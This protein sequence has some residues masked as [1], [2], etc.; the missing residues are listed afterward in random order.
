MGRVVSE[1]NGEASVEGDRTIRP[2]T[3]SV[4]LALE[5]AYQGDSATMPRVY[6]SGASGSRALRV[7]QGWLPCLHR[8]GQGRLTPDPCTPSLRLDPGEPVPRELAVALGVERPSQVWLYLSA[9][10][11]GLLLAGLAQAG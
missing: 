2:G 11:P 6:R 7:G 4:M 10:V 1:E 5:R 9:V 8:D 3:G